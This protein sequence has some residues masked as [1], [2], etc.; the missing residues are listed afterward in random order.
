MS[1]N[2]DSF[3]ASQVLPKA[4]PNILCVTLH[5]TVCLLGNLTEDKKI[6][7]AS[8]RPRKQNLQTRLPTS[9]LANL[10]VVSLIISDLLY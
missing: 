1:P 2:P 3:M 6:V 7:D 4:H 9:P 8:G 10:M 5:L